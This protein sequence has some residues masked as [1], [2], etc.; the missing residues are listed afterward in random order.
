RI[1]T[2]NPAINLATE[3]YYLTDKQFENDDIFLFWKNKNTIVIG[4]NQS[5]SSEVNQIEANKLKVHVVRRPSGGGAVYHD[6][7][8]ICFTFIKRNQKNNFKFKDCLQDIVDFLNSIN[9]NAQFSGRN[10]IVVNNRKISG[11][12]V[13]FYKN[14][15]L[16][17]G[18]LLFNVDVEKML[19][20]LTVDK[21]KLTSKGIESVKSRVVNLID[22]THL[23]SEEFEEKFINFFEQKYQTKREDVDL[24]NDYAIQKIMRQKYSNDE[25]TYGRD[26]EFNYTN[27]IKLEQGLLEVK[28]QNEKNIIKDIIFSTDGLFCNDLEAFTKLFLNQKY[29]IDN[30]KKLISNFD[31]N[32]IINGL[33]VTH[34]IEL[35]FKNG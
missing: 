18:T 4:K 3:E 11:N 16:I 35:L 1:L 12:A 26:F 14:D 30:I 33:T 34:I 21:S 15:Y 8:N 10:D 19:T 25:W 20:L 27:K 6:D 9:I 29:E 2:N 7:G 32:K 22:L 23:N 24:T 5:Y 31:L 28:L 17:H 13:L